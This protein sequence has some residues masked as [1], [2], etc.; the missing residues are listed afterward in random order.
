MRKIQI[1]KKNNEAVS[2]TKTDCALMFYGIKVRSK[3]NMF[4]RSV[5]LRQNQ[6]IKIIHTNLE[7]Y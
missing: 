2:Y 6:N 4:L 1:N 3:I 7:N 5:L